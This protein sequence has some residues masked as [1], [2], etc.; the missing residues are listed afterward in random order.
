MTVRDELANGLDPRLAQRL[1]A[2][3]PAKRL[4]I[5]R[6]MHAARVADDVSVIAPRSE[7]GPAPLS[8]SQE[9]MWH[10]ERNA[11]GLSSYNVPHAMRVVGPLD[12]ELL[13]TALSALVV[14][15]EVLR[16]TVESVAGE[17]RAVVQAA[18]PPSV[19]VVDLRS[20]APHDREF[21]L[22]RVLR[23]ATREPFDLGRDLLLR[24]TVVLLGVE[25]HALALVSHHFASD[26]GSARIL[27]GDLATLYN[28]LR[29]GEPVNLP[30]AAL[31]YS[32]F[33][34]WQRAYW[35]GPRLDELV[36]LW[37][38]QLAAAPER[39]GLPLDRPRPAFPS[40]A[41]ERRTYRFSPALAQ[42]VVKL[43]AAHG[44]TSFV[45]L[46][47]AFQTLLHRYN[48]QDDIYVGS[49]FTGRGRGEL[50]NV[51]GYFSNVL[52]LG[53][54]FAADPTFLELL[55][56]VREAYLFALD[57]SDVPFE[58]L[59]V[60]IDAR[61]ATERVGTFSAMFATVADGSAVP[62]LEGLSLTPIAIEHETAK[63][64]LMVGIAVTQD[65][66]SLSVEYR[67]QLLDGSTIDRM[68]EN[69]ETLLEGIVDDPSQR[70]SRLP[71]LGSTELRLVARP[72]TT[73]PLRAN[74]TVVDLLREQAARTPHAIAL[75]C[76]E[77]SLTYA[78][79]DARADQLGAYLR[80]QGVGP[81]VIVAV[82]LERSIEMVVAVLGVQRADRADAARGSAGVMV[83]FSSRK[84]R[85]SGCTTLIRPRR[86]S[87]ELVTAS[88]VPRTLPTI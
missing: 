30:A 72:H 41:G 43:G 69:F 50:G 3:S 80:T 15:H 34:T 20:C 83:D 57:H 51:L 61:S 73:A 62:L 64:D 42:A 25:D 78:Q 24:A 84:G 58:R 81:D 2:L 13:R 65:G 7:A 11:P 68:L 12:L 66:L 63:L 8:F 48:G 19:Q 46:L 16:T 40:F 85:P 18:R 36:S 88:G 9:V 14:R 56:Q 76:A 23:E 27:F 86:T 26:E 82:C 17:P 49:V 44:A 54:H 35:R 32:D 71:L 70:V 28:A 75:E 29:A 39:L 59:A 55:A 77:D 6:Q 87:C 31:N 38:T 53:A 4:F 47:A 21:E 45:T 67:T 52:P 1:A 79:L 60:E 10:I 33:S 74:A 5:E 22:H 37:Q